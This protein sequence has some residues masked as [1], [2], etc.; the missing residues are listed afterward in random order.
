VKSYGQHCP[1]S[2]ALDVVGDRWALLVMRELQLGPKRYT[3]LLDG[4]PGIGSSVL[5]TRLRDLETAGV[6]TKRELPAPTRVTVY[7]P[8][9]AG[10]ALGPVLLALGEWGE[11]HGRP[12]GRGDLARAGWI[13]APLARASG[14]VPSGAICEL[15]VGDEVF[16]ASAGADGVAIRAGEAEDPDAVVT[17]SVGDLRALVSGSTSARGRARVDGDARTANALLRA[18]AG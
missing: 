9:D 11:S 13:L 15:R 7:E 4:L 1:V 5:S 16:R 12:S 18:L 6:V 17:L 2:R 8:T 3:D 14:K 10:K